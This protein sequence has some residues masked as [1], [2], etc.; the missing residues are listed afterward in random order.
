M[1]GCICCIFYY[2]TWL[3][4][5]QLLFPL[6]PVR[7]S[8]FC[9]SLPFTSV[10]STHRPSLFNFRSTSPFSFGAAQ[11]HPHSPCV[12]PSLPGDAETKKKINPPFSF[13]FW[14]KPMPTWPQ[15]LLSFSLVI[16]PFIAALTLSQTFLVG[17][18]GHDPCL[19][20]FT[21]TA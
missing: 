20:G 18:A 3:Q 12:F 13:S 6:L 5:I 8:L 11:S 2:L 1:S 7:A 16:K 14:R 21:S 17:V 9:L 10:K 15:P 19:W 4:K